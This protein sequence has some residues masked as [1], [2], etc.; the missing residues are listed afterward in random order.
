MRDFKQQDRVSPVLS[1]GTDPKTVRAQ[2]LEYRCTAPS[3]PE[4]H[5]PGGKPAPRA[6]LGITGDRA[7]EGGDPAACCWLWTTTK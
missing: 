1:T 4:A 2:R 3:H 7:L 5:R 6:P